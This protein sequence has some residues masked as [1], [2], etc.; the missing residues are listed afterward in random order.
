MSP[1]HSATAGETARGSKSVSDQK[2]NMNATCLQS[3][4]SLQPYGK[5]LDCPRWCIDHVVDL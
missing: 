5:N 3:A 2:C 1:K 4:C